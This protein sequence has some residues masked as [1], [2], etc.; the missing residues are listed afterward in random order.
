MCVRACVRVWVCVGVSALHH[1]Q[2]SGCRTLETALFM[3]IITFAYLSQ[4]TI[5]EWCI[6]QRKGSSCL[7]VQQFNLTGRELA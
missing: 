2:L 5:L 4:S 3:Q 7:V 1:S 6:V